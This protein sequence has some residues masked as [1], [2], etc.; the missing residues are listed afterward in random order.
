MSNQPQTQ[1][2]DGL[3]I[4]SI[5]HYLSG[6]FFLLLTMIIAFMTLVFG[7]GAFADDLDLL[8]PTGIF[9][10]IALAFMALSVLNL[11]I[12]YG[13]WIRKPWARIGAIAL[14][15]VSLMMVPIGTISGALTLWYLLKAE[16]TTV[17]EKPTTA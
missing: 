4:I 6:G 3:T 5:W 1:R 12:G 14:S 8:I 7:V 10:I 17:F 16:V 2:P 9:G 11:V 13:L 15:I